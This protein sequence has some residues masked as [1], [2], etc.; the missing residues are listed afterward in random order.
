MTKVGE[1]A[2]GVR[3]YSELIHLRGPPEEAR[4]VKGCGSKPGKVDVRLPGKRNSNS[5]GARPVH[6]IITMMKW[7]RTSRLSIKN[8]LSL[9]KHLR[10]ALLISEKAVWQGFLDKEIY[11]KH[12]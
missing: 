8:F 11:Y 9:W 4:T 6:L 10:G 2:A 5:H 7:I 1:A 3:L 12:A